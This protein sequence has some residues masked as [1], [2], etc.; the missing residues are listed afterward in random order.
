MEKSTRPVRFTARTHGTLL[1]ARAEVLLSW[2]DLYPSVMRTLF[3]TLSDRFRQVTGMAA[4]SL[5][6][7][8]LGIVATS[9]RGHLLA[10]RLVT[11]LMAAGERLQVWAAQP[12]V[13]KLAGSWPHSL[14]IQELAPADEP[15]LQAP[16]LESDRRI[17]VWSPELD[18]EWTSRDCSVVTRCFGYSNHA[19]R[20]LRVKTCVAHLPC[21][22]TS[23]KSYALSG[24]SMRTRR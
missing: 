10:G 5:P 9:P 2:V 21:K 13:L 7:P 17:V 18:G 4:R 11:R 6:S 8:R 24:C 15:L 14:P 20:L 22:L 19:M 1:V 12:A 16:S 3:H 23:R